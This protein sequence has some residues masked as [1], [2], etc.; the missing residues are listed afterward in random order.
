MIETCQRCGKQSAKLE[1]CN[2]CD[3]KTCFACIKSSK[4]KKVGHLFICKDCWNNM[5]KR[6][7]YEGATKG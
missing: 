3:R 4:R 6:K 7:A 1:K 5:K 2:Y